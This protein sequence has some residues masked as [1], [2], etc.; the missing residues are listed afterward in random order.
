MEPCRALKGVVLSPRA[1]SEVRKWVSET[2]ELEP[3]DR[4]ELERETVL[5][6]ATLASELIADATD[7]ASDEATIRLTVDEATVCVEVFD[8][9]RRSVVAVSGRDEGVPAFRNLVFRRMADGW[10]SEEVG[11]GHF[12]S[13]EIVRRPST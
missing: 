10:S 5:D 2:L 13:C 9:P 3:F 12:S 4:A 1:P 6:L 11:D 8:A 7:H